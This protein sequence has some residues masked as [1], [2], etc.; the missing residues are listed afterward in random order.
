[1][2]V[3]VPRSTSLAVLGEAVKTCRRCDLFRNATQ[4]VFGEGS[5]RAEIVAVGEEPGDSEDRQGHPFVG[6]AGRLLTRAFADAGIARSDV[7]VTNAVKHFKFEQRGKRR[8]HKKPNTEEI[9]ACRPWLEAEMLAVK[10][11]L[12]IAL[13]ATA[14][15]SLLLKKAAIGPLR[16]KFVEH[17][18]ARALFVTTHP[19]AILRVEPEDRESEYARFVEELKMVAKWLRGRGA[20]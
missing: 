17:P 18:W 6:P 10:P 16:G 15:R 7:Y 5:K 19:A 8:I 4:A 1:M 13:G 14:L 20:A 9:L 2:S 3:E 11:E 12:I